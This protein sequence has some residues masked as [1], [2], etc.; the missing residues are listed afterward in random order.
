[1]HFN[2]SSV[3]FSIQF[4]IYLAATATFLGV[5]IIDCVSRKCIQKLRDCPLATHVSWSRR[6]TH[7]AVHIPTQNEALIY[8][9]SSCSLLRHTW[10][11]IHRI[12]LKPP[13]IGY[14]MPQYSISLRYPW[15]LCL[16]NDEVEMYDC[17]TGVSTISSPDHQC[18]PFLAGMSFNGL[19]V[20]VCYKKSGRIDFMHVKSALKSCELS[21]FAHQVFILTI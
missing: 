2:S 12:D 8:A 14:T 3:D 18:V 11:I 6:T 13:G 16:N 15:L 19:T 21:L 20:A 4:G 1:M 17:E 9:C 7:L 5:D 10:T